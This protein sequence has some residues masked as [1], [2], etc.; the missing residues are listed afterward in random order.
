MK[1][2]KTYQTNTQCSFQGICIS[3]LNVK[4]VIYLNLYICSIFVS[5]YNYTVNLVITSCQENM[6][7]LHS[8]R[9]GN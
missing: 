4:C 5:D 9:F 3:S 7:I 6:T 8:S 2:K 1:N